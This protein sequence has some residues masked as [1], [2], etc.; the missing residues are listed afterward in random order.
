MYSRWLPLIAATGLHAPTQ[1]ADV[2]PLCLDERLQE[3]QDGLWIAYEECNPSNLTGPFISCLP[4]KVSD[5]LTMFASDFVDSLLDLMNSEQVGLHDLYSSG[6]LEGVINILAV[7]ARPFLHTARG[8]WAARMSF[9]L[10]SAGCWPVLGQ[11]TRPVSGSLDAWPVTFQDIFNLALSGEAWRDIG[12]EA[13]VHLP[14]RMSMPPATLSRITPVQME[15][16]ATEISK[17][18]KSVTVLSTGHHASYPVAIAA[19]W[20]AMLPDY[21]IR[22]EDHSFDNRYCSLYGTCSSDGRFAWLGEHLRGTLVRTCGGLYLKCF[23]DIEQ[24]AEQ[25]FDLVVQGPDSPA[26]R[27]DVLLC[28]H[29]PYSCRLFMPFVERL[30]LPLL[31][32]FGGTLEAHVPEEGIEAW[33]EDFYMMAKNPLVQFAAIAPFLAEK[34]RY[35]SGAEIPAVRGFGFHV[36]EQGGTY[37][38]RRWSEVLVWKG[39]SECEDNKEA[40][41][42]L[43]ASVSKAAEGP[44]GT[45]QFVHLHALRKADGATYSSI[46]SFRAVVFVPYEVLLMT[47]YELYHVA[48]PLFIPVKELAAFFMYRGPVTFPHCNMVRHSEPDKDAGYGLHH[49]EEKQPEYPYSPFDRANV[50]ARL[51]WIEAYTDWYLWPHIVQYSSVANL[52]QKLHSTDFQ[53]VSAAMRSETEKAASSASLFWRAAFEKVLSAAGSSP[54]RR[55]GSEAQARKD[56][57][58]LK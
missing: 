51:A 27:A 52:V 1:S 30:G 41:S 9:D 24:L 14:P 11:R 53:A 6:C 26:S 34:M 57:S 31:G 20:N 44:E 23:K 47:F 40:F 8:Q 16:L 42:E 2:L 5:P 36:I 28:T 38:P 48:I 15:G 10:A 18:S 32:F 55:D 58:L 25:L 33:L 39:S 56:V 29:P 7:F 3:V 45:L 35:Q 13:E 43:I 4:H 22:L 49:G 50:T 19:M 54:L 12:D 21:T 37:M 46:A 17:I